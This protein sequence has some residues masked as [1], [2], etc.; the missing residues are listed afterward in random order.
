M[1]M[2]HAGAIARD[3]WCVLPERFPHAQLDAFVVMPNHVHGILVIIEPESQSPGSHSKPAVSQVIGAY[4]SLVV[5]CIWE[6]PRLNWNRD[7]LIWQR[8]SHDH[9]IRNER[10]LVM[11]REYI[12]GNALK[13]SRDRYYSG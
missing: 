3:Q 11:I 8:S 5:K 12:L 2:S 13:W 1:V 6:D 4:K 9:I 7:M 10:D